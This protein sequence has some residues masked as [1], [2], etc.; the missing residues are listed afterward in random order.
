MFFVI[1]YNYVQEAVV[2]GRVLSRSNMAEAPL[3]ADDILDAAQEVLRKHGVEKTNVVDIARALGMSHTN[4]YRHFPSKK[5]L[6]EA[7]AARWLH[8]V[9]SPLRQIAEDPT[10]PAAERLVAWFD[11]L[12]AAKRRKVLDDPELF[13]VYHGLAVATRE[14]VTEHV[15]DLAGQLERIIAD[16]VTRGEFSDHLD[17][18]AAATACLHATS[19]LHHPALLMQGGP[20]DEGETRTLLGLLLTG[21]RLGLTPLPAP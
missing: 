21:L 10:R 20:P 1:C 6:L 15:A 7:V 18:K 4:I 8:A 14:L 11:A 12:R 19:R 2:S 5:A 3:S 13:R 9:S 16:G 17:A